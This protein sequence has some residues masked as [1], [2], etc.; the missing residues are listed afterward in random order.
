MTNP[1]KTWTF[2]LACLLLAARCSA[3][4][5]TVVHPPAGQPNSRE[6]CTQTK[7]EEQNCMACASKPGCGYC[8]QPL[9]GAPVCQPGTHDQSASPSCAVPLTISNEECEG[10]PPPIAY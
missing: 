7:P 5:P 2:A 8:A 3:V 6:G 10:P 4:Q 9:G 1:V